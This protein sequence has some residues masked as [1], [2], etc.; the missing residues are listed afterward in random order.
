MMR[1]YYRIRAIHRHMMIRKRIKKLF[2]AIGPGFIT[3]ASDDDPSGIGTYAQTGAQFGYTQLWA[4]F[5]STPIMVVIQE[6][7]ARIGMV[8]GKGLTK[9]IAK[10]YSSW[11]LYGAVGLVIAANTI[12]IGADL[13]AMASSIQLLIPLPFAA[14]VIACALIIVLLEIFVS[15]KKYARILKW[16]ALSLFAYI[17]T[18]FIVHQSWGAIIHSLLI[19][20]IVFEKTYWL[21]IVALLG[22]TISP[23][24][25][26]WQ[27]DEEVEEEIA[28]HRLAQKEEAIPHLKLHDI[29]AMRW[30]TVIGMV[31]SNVITFFVII[32]AAATL[33]VAGMTTIQTADQA[34]QAL[35]PLAGHF[36]FL[37]FALGI[38]GTGL[39][40]IPVLAGSASYA[41]SETIGWKTGLYRKFSKAKGFYSIII[42]ATIIGVCINFVNIPTFTMLYY[43]AALNG[44]TAPLLMIL[45]IAIANDKKLMGEHTS[46]KTANAVAWIGV[47]AMGIAALALLYSLVF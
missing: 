21:N 29:R 16:L 35:I 33:G 17:V 39:L 47:V 20:H 34:A 32:T 22:T 30:D 43:T 42:V 45:I 4:I 37:L 10:K 18:A 23:Y 24:L 6:M 38:V 11:I 36:A 41:L 28:R 12:N 3:G 26:F 8:T 7:C 25:F 2:R 31:F 9:V 44:I 1:Y 15:Y 13:G 5:F 14:L 19:P 27:A 40:S 46:S